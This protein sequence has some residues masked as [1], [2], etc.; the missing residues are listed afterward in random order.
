MIRKELVETWRKM[1]VEMVNTENEEVGEEVG[2][3]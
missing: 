1:I 2:N 3:G